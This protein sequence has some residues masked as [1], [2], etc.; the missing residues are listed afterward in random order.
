[1]FFIQIFR[2]NVSFS[3]KIRRLSPPFSPA[4]I[5]RHRRVTQGTQFFSPLFSC[6]RKIEGL[7]ASRQYVSPYINIYLLTCRSCVGFSL[8]LPPLRNRKRKSLL[9]KLLSEPVANERERERENIF[10][11]LL[12]P[13]GYVRWYSRP[14]R[15]SAAHGRQIHQSR[16]GPLISEAHRGYRNC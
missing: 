1:M 14:N 2:E 11:L 16:K 13:Q 15:D 8:H 12:S 4:N 10:F 6:D 3:R 5:A 7:P 9:L